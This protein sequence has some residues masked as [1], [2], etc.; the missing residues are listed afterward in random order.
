MTLGLY[1]TP[2]EY[3]KALEVEGVKANVGTIN[4]L[5]SVTCH[6]KP[7]DVHLALA[8]LKELGLTK[9][10]TIKD[11]HLAIFARGGNLC[12]AEVGPALRLLYKDQPN[13]ESLYVAME[14]IRTSDTGPTAF[15]VDCISGDL[16]FGNDPCRPDTRL[17]PRQKIVFAIP[18]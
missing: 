15:A 18:V 3:T 8:T 10:S 14:A 9:R 17:D 6:K 13:G 7:F 11:L 1:K 2:E 12:L 5:Q 16:W 4:A